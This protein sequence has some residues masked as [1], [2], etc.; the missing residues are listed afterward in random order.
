MKVKRLLRTSFVISTPSA[1]DKKAATRQKNRFRTRPLPPPYASLSLRNPLPSQANRRI[2]SPHSSPT[3]TP[4]RLQNTQAS[5]VSLFATTQSQHA[6]IDAFAAAAQPSLPKSK[7][8]SPGSTLKD[9]QA[10][11]IKTHDAGV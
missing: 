9:C 1:R 4:A 6:E 11:E 7:S 8:S 3:S 10:G 5:N 2:P